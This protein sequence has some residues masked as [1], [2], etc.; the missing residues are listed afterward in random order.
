LNLFTCQLQQLGFV[1]TTLQTSFFNFV[2]GSFGCPPLSLDLKRG[3]G[4]NF[5]DQTGAKDDV[6]RVHSHVLDQASGNF[7]EV[8]S[9]EGAA[10]CG[11]K[12]RKKQTETYN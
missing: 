10:T 2:S 3:E 6:H 5:H 11:K 4:C 7:G 12:T 9:S 1:D 8:V